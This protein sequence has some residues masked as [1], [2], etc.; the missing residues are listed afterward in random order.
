MHKLLKQT[1]GAVST[2]KKIPYQA[3]LALFLVFGLTAV[4]ALRNNNQHMIVLRNN[5]YIADQSNG[6]VEGALDKLRVYVYS[7]MNTDLSSGGNAIKPPIQLKYTYERLQT[8]AEAAVNNTK[9]YTEAENVCQAQI[10]AS[11]SV[12]GKGRISCVQDYI[13]SHG[14]KQAASIPSALYQFDFISPAWSPD[15]AGWS[16]LASV[17]FFASFAVCYLAK[18]FK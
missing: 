6:D 9:L 18:R 7:H 13:L 8:Q 10:P 12:S 11:V 5:L 4:I 3:Y 16:I 1:L 2:V 17:F 15:T 14:G